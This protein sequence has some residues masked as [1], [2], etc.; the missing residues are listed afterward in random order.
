MT[1]TP[2][3]LSYAW[4]GDFGTN[5]S[6]VL[7]L[8]SCDGRTFPISS[9]TSI[10]GGGSGGCCVFDVATQTFY[11]AVNGNV[12]TTIF[13]K[14]QFRANYISDSGQSYFVPFVVNFYR[15]LI[16]YPKTPNHTISHCPESPYPF[17]FGHTAG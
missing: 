15:P 12:I 17:F 3:T 7:T 16:R 14:I 1:I 6:Y 4:P 2:D 5:K 13:G 10:T 8:T 9:V 11:V